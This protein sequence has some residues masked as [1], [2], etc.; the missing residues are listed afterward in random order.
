METAESLVGEEGR[1][2]G[3]ISR[4]TGEVNEDEEQGAA[5]RLQHRKAAQELLTGK[6]REEARAFER[7]ESQKDAVTRN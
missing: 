5:G 2:H 6:A 7:E 1:T 3:D 4:R